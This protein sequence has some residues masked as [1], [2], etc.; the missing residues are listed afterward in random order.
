M[1]KESP[2]RNCS[3]RNV[4]CHAKCEEYNEFLE[5][6]KETREARGAAVKRADD[7][8][9]AKRTI[10]KLYWRGLP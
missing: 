9:T 2:C 3:D 8:I 1:K 7:Y 10:K 4:G 6:V 5:N